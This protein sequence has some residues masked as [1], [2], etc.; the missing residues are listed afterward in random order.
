[1]R[2]SYQ[3]TSSVDAARLYR[4]LRG[5][6]DAPRLSTA[7]RAQFPKDGPNAFDA[8]AFQLLYDDD[9][10]RIPLNLADEIRGIIGLM[11]KAYVS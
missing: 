10:V 11:H 1:M 8:A 3:E 9:F 7:V 4:T 6:F 2:D 5:A